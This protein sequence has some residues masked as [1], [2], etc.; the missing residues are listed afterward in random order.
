MKWEIAHKM[1]E[2]SEKERSWRRNLDIISSLLPILQLSFYTT[3]RCL[4]LSIDA[5]ISRQRCSDLGFENPLA[6]KHE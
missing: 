4:Q 3:V 6:S 2:V 5:C 1:S